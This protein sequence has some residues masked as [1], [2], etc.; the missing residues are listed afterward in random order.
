MPMQLYYTNYSLKCKSHNHFLD[1]TPF[2]ISLSR[3]NR[4]S[5][6]SESSSLSRFPTLR[7][8]SSLYIYSQAANPVCVIALTQGQ[9]F[10]CSANK[11]NGSS[12]ILS[13]LSFSDV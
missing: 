12:S 7:G 6:P 9:Y 1:P 3:L 11:S 10:L 8:S 4:L 2:N 13:I 5:L